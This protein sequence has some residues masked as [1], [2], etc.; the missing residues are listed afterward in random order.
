M[1]RLLSKRI[2]NRKAWD[3]EA[4]ESGHGD[5]KADKHSEALRTCSGVGVLR[6]REYSSA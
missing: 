3:E 2:F 1:V 5:N 6:K 4:V